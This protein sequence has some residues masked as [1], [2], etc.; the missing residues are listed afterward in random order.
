MGLR[1]QTARA[2]AREKEAGGLDVSWAEEKGKEKRNGP[3]GDRP[4]GLKE[5]KGEGFWDFF[6]LNSFQIHFS[7]FSNFTH[8]IKL[9]IR[10]MMHKHL[11]FLTLLK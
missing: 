8:T 3:R 1:G 6:F 11:L 7:N 5:R 9:C 10:I 2:S 4:A